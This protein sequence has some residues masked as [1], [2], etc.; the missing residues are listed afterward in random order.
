MP[1]CQKKNRRH[2][3][4]FGQDAAGEYRGAVSSGFQVGFFQS[5]AVLFVSPLQQEGDQKGKDGDAREDAHGQGVVVEV[6]AHTVR[7]FLAHDAVVFQHAADEGG[8][9]PKA[10]VL[11]EEDE[12]IGR[13]CPG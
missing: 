5:V 9:A 11:D 1:G 2:P 12:G 10:D 13:R 7:D 8:D 3:A 6:G 4:G